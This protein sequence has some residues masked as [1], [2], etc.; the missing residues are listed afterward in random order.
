MANMDIKLIKIPPIDLEWTEWYAWNKFE[1][2][3][4][5][6]S[7]GITPPKSP[8][9]YEV[10]LIEIEQRLTIGKASDLRMRVKQGLVK[11]KVPH[12]SGKVIRENEDTSKILIRW[13]VT[14]RPAAVEEEL[15]KQHKQ[16]FGKLPKHTDHT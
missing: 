6:D 14:D 15:H 4:R 16:I 8:G 2:D 13:A 10:R 5:S 12:S 9:V 11:G 3:A 7:N 1:F